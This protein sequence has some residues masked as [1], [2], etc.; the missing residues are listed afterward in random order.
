MLNEKELIEQFILKLKEKLNEFGLQRSTIIKI[1]KELFPLQVESEKLISYCQHSFYL[2]H[3]IFPQIDEFQ[4]LTQIIFGE[5]FLFEVHSENKKKKKNIYK[6][7]V[8]SNPESLFLEEKEEE[9]KNPEIV[10][11]CHENFSINLNVSQN[12]FLVDSNSTLNSDMNFTAFI[13]CQSNYAAY[14]ASE[15]VS[16]SPGKHSNPLFIYGSTGLGKT[17][18]LHSVGNEILKNNPQFKIRYVNSNDFINDVIHR[19][20]KSGKMQEIRKKYNQCDVLLVDDI[21]FLENKEVCQLEFFY[22]FNELYQKKK[23][24]I[25]TSD[26]FPKDIPSIEERLKSRFLQGLL[27]DIELPSFEDRV[28]ILET[29]IQQMKLNITSSQI[30]LIATHAKTNIRELEGLLKN[31]SVKQKL[32]GSCYADEDILSVLRKRFPVDNSAVNSVD[33][34]QIQKIVAEFF[35]IEFNELLGPQRQKNIVMARHIAMYL[36]KDLLDC[37]VVQIAKSFGRKDHTTAIHAIA[38]IKDLIQMDKNFA[39]E[40]QVMKKKITEHNVNSKN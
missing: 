35:R 3:I 36:A 25:M 23:Q 8:A 12:N 1:C 33:I 13:C 24:I 5:N 39:S 4:K 6:E 21:H 10:E 30:F 22:T 17:H 28:A 37:N 32:N 20:I 40:Y 26:K 7:E 14:T 27:V 31:L 38:K 18:L 2:D 16:K 34:S 29:K 19:G 9:V 11:N 15:A